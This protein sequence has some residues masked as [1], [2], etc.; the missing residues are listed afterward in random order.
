METTTQLLA[1]DELNAYGKANAMSRYNDAP[2]DWADEIIAR[3]KQD[4]P[5]RGFEI[6]EVAWS[7]F[8]SQGDGA[9]WTGMV[10]LPRFIEYHNKPDNHDYTQYFVLNELIKEGWTDTNLGVSR[11]GFY[12][13]HSGTM[14]VEDI[15]DNF[16]NADG[17][18]IDAG[19]L[20]G[21]NVH[22][23]MRSISVDVRL[24][25]LHQWVMNEVRRYANDIYAQ[26]RDEYDEY[27]SEE[28]FKEVCDINGWRFDVN[29]YLQEE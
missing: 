2:D 13:N 4:G 9:S 26:L 27:A 7:G 15:S 3:A 5:E 24:E 6:D 22:E 28:R 11:S 12:Y 19:I 18:S 14:R 20:E 29:G 8:S 17:A 21:A 23:L 1:F 25:E 16:Y 10:R